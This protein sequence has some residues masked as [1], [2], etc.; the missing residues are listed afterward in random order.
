[1]DLHAAGITALDEIRLVFISKKYEKEITRA[2]S[3]TSMI[4]VKLRYN[5]SPCFLLA[6]IM[7][8]IVLVYRGGVHLNAF[9]AHT[10]LYYD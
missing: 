9:T 4:E 5:Y 7:I 6:P 10:R 1:M 3:A 2:W 8:N